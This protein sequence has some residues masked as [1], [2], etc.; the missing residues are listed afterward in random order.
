MTEQLLN[1]TKSALQDSEEV[2][3]QL[4]RSWQPL[5]GKLEAIEAHLMGAKGMAKGSG[6]YAR[7]RRRTRGET[8]GH[9]LC[10]SLGFGL[11]TE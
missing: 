4:S 8:G 1:Q 11:P 9:A 6:I 2:V 3:M 7:R 5:L 10:H